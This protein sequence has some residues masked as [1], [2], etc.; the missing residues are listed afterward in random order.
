M[1][2]NNPD[3]VEKIV[4]QRSEVDT[5][6]SPDGQVDV[7]SEN[8]VS[9]SKTANFKVSAK[10]S[11][12]VDKPGVTSVDLL[13]PSARRE[14]VFAALT[15]AGMSIDLNTESS[16]LYTQVVA[17]SV[18][19]GMVPAE[20]SFINTVNR[21]G[22]EWDNEPMF[23]NAKLR[24]GYPS[25]A[26]G[27]SFNTPEAKKVIIR[28]ALGLGNHVSF[29]LW[30][31]GF[32]LTLN[33]TSEGALIEL[34][35]R[36]AE[37]RISVGRKTYGLLYAAETALTTQELCSFAIDLIYE[38]NV[39]DIDKENNIFDLI[40][41][42]DLPLLIA[43]LASV[44]WPAGFKMHRYCVADPASCRHEITEK[45]SIP[46][47]VFADKTRFGEEQMRQMAERGRNS[48][49]IDRIRNYQTSGHVPRISNVKIG[50]LLINFKIPTLA[51]FF[52]NSLQWA[53]SI[54]NTYATAVAY[55]EKKRAEVIGSHQKATALRNWTHIVASIQVGDTI[56]NDKETIESTLQDM[57][58][59]S[60]HRETFTKAAKEFIE[61]ATSAVVAIP[62]YDCPACGRH[63]AVS[64]PFNL[65]ELIVL[66]PIS[67]FFYLLHQRIGQYQDN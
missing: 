1:N 44:V 54:E 24:G 37:H 41:L 58:S 7:T 36:I 56:I 59:S 8:T 48:I 67:V 60:N 53:A 23:E 4:F 38:T 34:N 35:R 66:D 43:G 25:L 17:E 55:D 21:N 16:Q 14:A 65:P 15:K 30:H 9:D 19:S 40:S 47:L 31:S 52:S 22:S 12:A 2:D 63:Q 45:V 3:R 61:N 50:E 20:D 64:N 39:K 49:S 28:S 51:D 13:I 42:L 18:A 11:E 10:I 46:R 32:W 33:P 27:G 5:N 6:Q 26:K 57:S 29:P 62:T